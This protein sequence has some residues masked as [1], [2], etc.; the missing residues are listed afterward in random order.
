MRIVKICKSCTVFLQNEDAA[1]LRKA[2]ANVIQTDEKLA[3]KKTQFVFVFL[4][5]TD[6]FSEISFCYKKRKNVMRKILIYSIG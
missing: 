2:L 1:L 3:M 4:Q 5:A 6:K